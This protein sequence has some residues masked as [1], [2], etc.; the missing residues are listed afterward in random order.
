LT[1]FLLSYDGE[2]SLMIH[3]NRFSSGRHPD[4]NVKLCIQ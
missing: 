2:I 3:K 1:V 4:N